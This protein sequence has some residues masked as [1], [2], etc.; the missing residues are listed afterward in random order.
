MRMMIMFDLPTFSLQDLREYRKFRKF[1]IENGFI[2]MQ[3]SIYTKL[4]LNAASANLMSKQVKKVVP[5]DGLVQM[6]IVTEKQFAGMELLSGELNSTYI[7][8]DKRYLE[9]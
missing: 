9:L 8:S 1:L 7:N 6:L 5:K 2:M 4:L 3:E